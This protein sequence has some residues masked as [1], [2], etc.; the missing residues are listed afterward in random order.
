MTLQTDHLATQTTHPLEQLTSVEYQQVR[1]ILD[2]A[3]LV[4]D[5]TRF[6][7]VGL[8]E[9]AKE[10][11]YPQP[12]T[13]V[14]RRVRVML[15]DAALS[16]S[17]DLTV[18]L[19]S[20]SVLSSRE[21][22]PATEG[23]L[24]VLLE[25]FEIIEQILAVDPGWLAAL[26]SRG[27]SPAQ[28]RV[29]PLSAGVFEYENETGKRLL[30][31]LGFRQDHPADHAWAH[32]ID[33]LVAFVDVEKRRVNHLIDDGPVPVPEVNGNYNDPAIHGELRTDM[34]PIDVIQP[35]GASFTLEGNHLSWLGWDLRV[36]FDAREG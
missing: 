7:Y 11:L 29:A 24:P 18:S 23:Q 10:L 4:E 3:G 1:S 35:E 12:G 31:G 19:R 27:L 9:P 32:P 28:V 14:D 25:E 21:L 6:A 34:K 22:D 5:T 15:W 33:G 26:E 17:L 2:A 36:G 30:R 8:L 20:G 16:R 13:D